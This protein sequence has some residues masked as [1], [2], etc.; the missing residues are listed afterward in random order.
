MQYFFN[1]SSGLGSATVLAPDWQVVKDGLQSNLDQV[2]KYYYNRPHAVKSH[3]FLVRLL[4]NIGVPYSHQLERFH[5]IVEARALSMSVGFKMTSPI[6]KGSLFN[7]IFFGEGSAEV[8]I[9][10]DESFNPY[11]AHQNWRV[12]QAVTVISHP[13]SDL[14]YTLANGKKSGTDTGISFIVINIPMLAIQFRAY[15]ES[16]QIRSE[17][18]DVNPQTVAQF[19][20]MH[21]LPNMM[22]SQVNQA[23]FN[24]AY[25]IAF[26]APMGESVKSHPFMLLNYEDRVDKVYRHLCNYLKGNERDMRAMLKS[27]P[28]IGGDFHSLMK[29]PELVPT[30]QY[31][32]VEV[33]SR[34]KV[35]DFL[36]ELSPSRCLN[37][38]ASEINEI[39]RMLKYYRNDSILNVLPREI[40]DDY[41]LAI[42]NI[43][44]KVKRN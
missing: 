40:A 36:T 6:S 17:T 41:S 19:I 30:R 9:A 44:K 34:I 8:L 13:K 43:L 7:G 37:K 14:G 33:L 29:L 23:L 27:F 32:W 25:N 1:S 26:S 22:K 38:N 5:S 35:I 24:R 31:V 28:C 3:H 18:Y 39:T 21:V 11:L 10:S 15:M 20:H 42:E 16:Q 4:N 2:Q 12:L